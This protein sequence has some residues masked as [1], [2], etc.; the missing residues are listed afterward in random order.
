MGRKKGD[1]LQVLLH[2]EKEPELRKRF[3]AIKQEYGIKS[4]AELV[5]V[6]INSKYKELHPQKKIK[7]VS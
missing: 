7:K 6:L 4:N 1:K 2:L 5:R 3:E